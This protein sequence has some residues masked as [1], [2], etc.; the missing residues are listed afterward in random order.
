MAFSPNRP[1]NSD[2]LMVF[3]DVE[4]DDIVIFIYDSGEEGLFYRYLGEWRE[5]LG[6]EDDYSID[7]D[8][9]SLI[10]VTPDFIPVFDE[11]EELEEIIPISEVLE[12]KSVDIDDLED[13]E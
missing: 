7:L 12:Y 2:D 3:C 9:L 10:Y 6:P 5:M 11:A 1:E 4:E 13:E 8:D